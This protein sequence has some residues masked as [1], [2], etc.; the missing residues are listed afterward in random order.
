MTAPA[1]GLALVLVGDGLGVPLAAPLK[2]A[3][4]VVVLV[5]L[6]RLARHVVLH[7]VAFLVYSFFTLIYYYQTE[8]AQARM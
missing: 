7:S 3:P 8:A 5:A 1:L 6:E 2:V 4:R